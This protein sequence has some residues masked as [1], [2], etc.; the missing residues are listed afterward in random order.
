MAADHSAGAAALAGP[1]LV[2]PA[3]AKINLTLRVLGRRPDGYHEIES[4]V[5]FADVSDRLALRPGPGL[6]L[7]VAGPMAERSGPVSDNLVLVAAR[8]LADRVEGLQLGQFGLIK[9]LPVGAGMGGGSADAAA[10]LRL[11]ARANGFDLGDARVRAAALATG[12]DVTVCLEQRPRWMHGIGEK[13]SPPLMMPKLFGLLVHPGIGVATREVFDALSAP[14]AN[15]TSA[16]QK[17]LPAESRAF[18]AFLSAR[19]NDLEV[20]ARKVCPIVSD[21]LTALQAQPGCA[22]AR[23]SGSGS[24]CFGLFASLAAAEFGARLIATE[25]PGWWVQAATIGEVV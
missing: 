6:D 8:A 5:A 21:V 25:H 9:R 17:T 12:A 24:A 3:F 19:S 1:A 20:A 10:A 14:P 22:L 7:H 13:L 11:L 15:S 2:E 4:L 23:M 18:I 16:T